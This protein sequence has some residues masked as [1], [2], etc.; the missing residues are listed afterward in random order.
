MPSVDSSVGLVPLPTPAGA[1]D[2]PF[3]DAT[4]TALLDYCAF[5][6]KWSLDQK[7]ATMTFPGIDAGRDMVP[8]ANRYTQAP[9]SLLMARKLP[10]LFLW[11]DG[12]STKQ[13]ISTVKTC[14]ERDFT[15]LYVFERLINIDQLNTYSGLTATIGAALSRAFDRLAHPAYAL[16]G[17]GFAPGTDIRIM[18]NL[19][20]VEYLGDQDG[21]LKELPQQSSRTVATAANH[22]TSSAQGGIQKGY[23]SL[24]AK[25]RVWELIGQDSLSDPA[26]ATKDMKISI[27]VGDPANPLPYMQRVLQQPD[28]SQIE[29]PDQVGKS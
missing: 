10:A 11:W 13:R 23:P 17:S 26:D 29:D 20:G 15:L 25:I 7:I 1:Q 3:A 2:A 4:E 22:S 28:G 14:R 6:I 12:K 24:S 19:R 21:F 16:A 8:A 9:N 5:W 27:N 18:F